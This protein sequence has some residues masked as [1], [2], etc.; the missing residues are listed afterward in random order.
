MEKSFPHINSVMLHW[1]KQPGRGVMYEETGC[2]CDQGNQ[3]KGLQLCVSVSRLSEQLSQSLPWL[4]LFVSSNT[5]CC[6]KTSSSTNLFN[7]IVSTRILILLN[8][9]SSSKIVWKLHL[10]YS[11]IEGETLTLP[12]H[13]LL[14]KLYILLCSIIMIST[15]IKYSYFT[16]KHYPLNKLQFMTFFVIDKCPYYNIQNPQ[17]SDTPMSISYSGSW[18]H[19]MSCLV[20]PRVQNL[21]QFKFP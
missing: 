7:S 10:L 12:M 8:H 4:R 17:N 14:R 15:F 5:E 16:N 18:Q 1:W 9:I 11:Y 20:K 6:H 21:K 3:A 2:F 13:H 19:Q